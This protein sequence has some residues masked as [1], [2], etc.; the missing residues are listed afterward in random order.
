MIE[1]TEPPSTRRLSSQ[2]PA[3]VDMHDLWVAYR[4]GAPCPCG[5]PDHRLALSV[6]VQPRTY[7][8]QCNECSWQSGWFRI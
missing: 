1:E 6:N 5:H 7:S 4:A 2:S 3:A 8:L